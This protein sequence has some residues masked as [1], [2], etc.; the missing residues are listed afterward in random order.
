[1]E[2]EPASDQATHW[3]KAELQQALSTALQ[4]PAAAELPLLYAALDRLLAEQPLARQLQIAGTILLQIAEIYTD[5]FHLS[6]SDWERQHQPHEPVV[7]LESCVDLFV[8]S[9]SLNLSE[10][11]EVTSPAEY[12]A[13]RKAAGAAVSEI[14]KDTLLRLADQVADQV[15]DRAGTAGWETADLNSFDL[16]A[17]IQHLAH[18]E[19]I[20]QCSAAIRDFL[21]ASSQP[22]SRLFDMQQQLNMP[23]VELWLGLLLAGYSLEQRGDFYDSQSIWVVAM[24]EHSE[25]ISSLHGIK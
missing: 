16:A 23:L 1:M 18:D 19:N 25:A 5:R 11:F 8:Q 6:I 17:Q 15:A 2:I 13:H 4:F 7:S 3:L 24:R 21:T 20:E 10:L 14:D 22:A 12:P 9:L